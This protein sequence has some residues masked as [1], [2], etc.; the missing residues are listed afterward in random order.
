[1]IDPD[2]RLRALHGARWRIALL[3]T[4]SMIAVYF[5]FIALIA[6]NRPL[7]ARLVT[8]GLSVGIVLGALVIVISWLLTLVYVRWANSH[9]DVELRALHRE[10]ED[11]AASPEAQ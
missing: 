5:G 7:L 8:P 1:L 3:L 11:R 2:A 10:A 4:A 9:Y 6:F